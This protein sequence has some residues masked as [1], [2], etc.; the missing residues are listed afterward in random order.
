MRSQNPSGDSGSNP[1]R[2]SSTYAATMDTSRMYGG[3]QR[4]R[5]SAM[6]LSTALP[7]TDD[8]GID[9]QECYR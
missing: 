7:D 5:Q 2:A 1:V 6:Q 9:R 3:L 8:G 4:S